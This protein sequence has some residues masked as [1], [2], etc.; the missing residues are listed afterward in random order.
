MTESEMYEGLAKVA[1]EKYVEPMIKGTFKHIKAGAKDNWEKFKVDFDIAFRA[2]L[3]NSIEKYGKVKTILYRTEPKNLY[4]F[5]ECPILLKHFL[6]TTFLSKKLVK[7]TIKGESVDVL[8]DVSHFIIIQGTGGIGKSTFLKH[9]FLNEI[10]KRD[11]IPVFIELKELNTID[12]AYDISKFIFQRLDDLGSTLDREYMTYAL[13]SGCFLF[14]LDGCDEILTARKDIFFREFDRFCDRYSKNYFILSSRPYSD[15]VEFQRFTVF[16][17]QPFSK[18]QALSLIQKIEYDE[19]VKQRFLTA[20]DDHLFETHKSFASN[21]LL[22]NIML[23]TF[24]NYADIPEKMH[25]F[26]ANAFE[27]LYYKH[28]ATKSGYHREMRCSLPYDLFRKAFAQFCF[29]TYCKGMIE[30]TWEEIRGILE[31][32]QEKFFDLIPRDF[33]VDLVNALCVLY[34]DGFQYGFTH[35]SFQEYFTA[36]FLQEL[37]DENMK[38]IAVG[39]AKKD[40]SRILEDSMFFMLCDMAKQ[41]FE[42]NVLLPLLIELEDGCENTDKYDFYYDVLKPD[43]NYMLY[44]RED[45]FGVSFGSSSNTTRFLNVVVQ[46]YIHR[47]SESIRLQCEASEELFHCLNTKMNY[48]FTEDVPYDKYRKDEELYSLIRRTWLGEHIETLATL[49]EHLEQKREDEEQDLFS[50][51]DDL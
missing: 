12:G 16:E 8:L 31:K 29:M 14:L 43:I 28:D 41:R 17:L 4:D 32:I 13:K 45:F 47:S 44:D 20:L 49:R 36:V 24:D 19:E 21:P 7:T 6:R 40:S 2:Y 51:M 35:R 30:F 22:L 37:S 5:F 46:N 23:L 15:F 26:Y 1:L 38:K 27:T 48:Q 39:L 33:I 11:L 9:L 25:L 18:Q 10:S 42:Q 50:M 34:R 3:E